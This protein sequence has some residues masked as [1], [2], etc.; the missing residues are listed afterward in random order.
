LETHDKGDFTIKSRKKAMMHEVVYAHI[1]LTLGWMVPLRIRISL[2]ILNQLREECIKATTQV[3]QTFETATFVVCS[4]V[5]D[6]QVTIKAFQHLTISN[7][8]SDE[9]LRML[10]AILCRK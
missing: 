6:Y 4:F 10:M 2:T 8:D 3:H 5:H 9:V 7:I 1:L